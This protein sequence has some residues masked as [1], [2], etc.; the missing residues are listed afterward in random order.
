MSPYGVDKKIGGD[1]EDNVSFMEKCV[2]SIVGTN[3]RTGKPYTKGEKIA[4]CKTQLKKSKSD[5]DAMSSLEE[6]QK[7]FLNK[8]INRGKSLV[9]AQALF[10]AYLAKNDFD[11]DSLIENYD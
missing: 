11:L 9:Q 8:E 7:Q 3:K 4:I 5:I 1:N 10:E 6:I 2:N